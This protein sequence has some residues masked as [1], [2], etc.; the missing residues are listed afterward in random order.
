MNIK[1]MI[2]DGRKVTFVEY[3]HKELWYVTE[4]GFEFPVP[5]ED[6]GDGIF[7]A[8]DRAIFFLRYI[9]KHIKLLENAKQEHNG[10]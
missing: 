7:L 5:I 10:G 1:E 4:T 8:E 2:S 9:R 6:T 3:K